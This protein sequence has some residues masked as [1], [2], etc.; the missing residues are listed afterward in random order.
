MGEASTKTA[1]LKR[2]RVYEYTTDD[3]MVLWSFSRLPNM[4]NPPKRLVLTSKLGRHVMN[5]LADLRLASELDPEED[6]FGG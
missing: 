2:K 4:V 1:I 6:E 5:F 3:G